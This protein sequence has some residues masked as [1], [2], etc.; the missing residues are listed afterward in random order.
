MAYKYT[1]DKELVKKAR[2]LD[3]AGLESSSVWYPYDMRFNPLRTLCVLEQLRRQKK[4]FKIYYPV[5]K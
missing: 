5:K 1:E 3:K 4:K 2:E